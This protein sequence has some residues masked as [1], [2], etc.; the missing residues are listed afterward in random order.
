MSADLEAEIAKLNEKTKSDHQKIKVRI[1]GIERDKIELILDCDELRSDLVDSNKEVETMRE[2]H[3]ALT[4][5]FELL[6]EENN[7]VRGSYA[8]LKVK[9]AAVDKVDYYKMLISSNLFQLF[10]HNVLF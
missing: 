7:Q 2:Q 1:G 6:V 3:I 10:F 8:D 5:N 4:E 9:S